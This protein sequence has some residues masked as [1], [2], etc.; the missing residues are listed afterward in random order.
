MRNNKSESIA[1]IQSAIFVF[2]LTR[3]VYLRI[4]YQ[5]CTSSFETIEKLEYK[6]TKNK[7]KKEMK[8]II[9]TIYLLLIYNSPEII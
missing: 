7:K 5:P 8:I 9:Q 2:G 1:N 4:A 3:N 6:N